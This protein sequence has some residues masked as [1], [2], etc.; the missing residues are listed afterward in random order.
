KR[1]LE[2]REIV[3]SQPK[4]NGESA[5]ARFTTV[6]P[7]P[8]DQM[9]G[10]VDLLVRVPVDSKTRAG[11]GPRGEPAYD[12]KQNIKYQ[13]NHYPT[14]GKNLIAHVRGYMETTPEGKK[15]FHVFEVQSDWAQQY[16]RI[17]EELER[18]K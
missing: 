8:L 17:K 4:G 3:E 10:A 1:Y 2:L 12:Y 11:T 6:N 15:V 13:S 7:K 14:E 9:P 5:T 16:Q 18:V